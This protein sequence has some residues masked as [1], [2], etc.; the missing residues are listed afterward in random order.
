MAKH[1]TMEGSVGRA[2]TRWQGR[3]KPSGLGRVW[4]GKDQ[5]VPSHRRDVPAGVPY[6]TRLS[7][8]RPPPRRV[9]SGITSRDGVIAQ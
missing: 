8:R 6:P 7:G 1:T 4:V 3:I 5:G 9:R 2:S